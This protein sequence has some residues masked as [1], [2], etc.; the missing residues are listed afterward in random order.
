[1]PGVRWGGDGLLQ[2]TV[3]RVRWSFGAQRI[4]LTIGAVLAPKMLLH[5]DDI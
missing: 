5:R 2:G 3:I 4:S 1:M